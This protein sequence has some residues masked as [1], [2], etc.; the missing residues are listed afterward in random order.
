ME[1]DIKESFGNKILLKIKKS[2]QLY[3]EIKEYFLNNF[4]FFPTY[5]G[6]VRQNQWSNKSFLNTIKFLSLLSIIEQAKDEKWKIAI[7]IKYFNDWVDDIHDNVNYFSKIDDWEQI[8]NLLKD[9]ETDI[10]EFKA[11][12]G[13]SLGKVQNIKHEK[14]I[15]KEILDK[16]SKT[17][18]AMANSQGGN[19]LIGVIERPEK[20]QN[21]EIKLEMVER[22][23]HSFLD[24]NYSLAK[25]GENLD[26]KRLYLQ[27]VLRNL[28]NERID[29][30]DSLFDISFLTL[31]DEKRDKQINL[32]K[33]KVK[34]SSKRI[35]YSGDPEND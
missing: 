35:L 18:L 16:I 6:P 12:F 32:L 33:I 11:T 29:F 28:T 3:E 30:L 9:G 24:I 1:Y 14:K 10:V 5:K 34:K 19:I 15:K 21:E 22:D 2:A 31:Y 27:E 26:S 4:T 23:N 17:I 25:E 20:I 7:F 13:Y 8:K